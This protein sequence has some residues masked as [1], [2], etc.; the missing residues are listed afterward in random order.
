MT[1]IKLCSAY[2]LLSRSVCD[3]PKGHKGPHQALVVW[4]DE[5]AGGED[6]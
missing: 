4:G 5:E 1:E 3:L 2:D 6:E